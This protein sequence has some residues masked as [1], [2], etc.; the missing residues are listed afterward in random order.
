MFKKYLSVEVFIPILE[1]INHSFELE[2]QG[3]YYFKID[4]FL[5]KSKINVI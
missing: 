1:R 3:N 2:F 4:S 5:K